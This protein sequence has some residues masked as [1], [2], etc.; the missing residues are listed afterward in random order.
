MG[1][2]TRRNQILQLVQ[3]WR[4]EAIGAP[5]NAAPDMPPMPPASAFESAPEQDEVEDEYS[6][7]SY[8]LDESDSSHPVSSAI[9]KVPEF[10]PNPGPSTCQ[11]SPRKD[12]QPLFGWEFL[13]LLIRN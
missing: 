1:Q 3:G 2:P 12:H 5:A 13:I 8:E 11:F 4:I 7:L 9:T 6:F 10:S